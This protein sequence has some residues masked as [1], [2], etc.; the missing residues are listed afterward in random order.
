MAQPQTK[1]GLAV[2]VLGSVYCWFWVGLMG[3]LAACAG[4]ILT[5]PF[6]PWVD[7]RR[8][9]MD[10][11]NHTWGRATLWGLPRIRGEYVGL[12]RARDTKEAYL[13]CSNHQSVAD[14]IVLLSAFRSGKFIVKRYL[15]FFPPF[16]LMFLLSGYIM[17]TGNSGE[18]VLQK[19]RSWLSRGVN[20]LNFPEGTRSPD[21]QLQRFHRSVFTVACDLHL[22]VLPVAIWGTRDVI[23]KGSWLYAFHTC[24]HLEVLP[25]LDPGSD[26]AAAAKATRSA[27]QVAIDSY[28]AEL[29][30][31]VPASS[32]GGDQV[33][34]LR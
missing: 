10:Y 28:R 5:I 29:A 6:N 2:R 11:V 1:I 24:G 32:H 31:E 33:A 19:V 26:S 16:A 13:V 17:V 30:R 22:K 18:K 9:V 8:R 15:Y 7:P 12:E 25:P 34:A 23:S 27:I 3:L 21:G 20:V 14:I 4:L